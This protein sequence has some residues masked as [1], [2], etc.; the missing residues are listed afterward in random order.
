MF[1]ALI[2]HDLNSLST[3]R[4]YC[5]HHSISICELLGQEKKWKHKSHVITLT[6]ILTFKKKKYINIF[7]LWKLLYYNKYKKKEEKGEQH[8]IQFFLQN[9]NYYEQLI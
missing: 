5:L 9:K 8:K 3:C 7:L 6:S 1:L 4:T 2:I